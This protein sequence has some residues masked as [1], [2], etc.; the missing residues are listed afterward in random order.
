MSEDTS[1]AVQS[2]NSEVH[3]IRKC[4]PRTSLWFHNASYTHWSYN[5]NARILVMVI[6]IVL[7]WEQ[8]T[9]AADGE[10]TKTTVGRENFFEIGFILQFYQF[11]IITNLAR[12][13]GRRSSL[14]ER[15]RG[16]CL[17]VALRWVGKVSPG[18][19][20]DF[21]M[22]PRATLHAREWVVIGR[23]SM[24]GG[25]LLAVLPFVNHLKGT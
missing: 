21:W 23:K 9:E 1:K 15:W 7:T 4:A 19:S 17:V 8:R 22:S 2:R 6:T 24:T 14:A 10:K 18:N 13:H 3:Q 5:N 12:R 20:F 16:V 11:G 25:R